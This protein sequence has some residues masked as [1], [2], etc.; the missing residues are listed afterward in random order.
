MRNDVRSHLD[1]RAALR[2]LSALSGLLAAST[3]ISGVALAETSPNA[4]GT[5]PFAVEIAPR[6]YAHK[7]HV[8]LYAPANE[9][10]I[11]NAGFVVGR[12]AVAVIDTGG[13]ARVGAHLHQAI[14][15]VTQLPI[16][17]VINTHMHPDHV[18][19]NS[20]FEADQPAFV[21]HHKLAR[22]LSARAERYLAI[23]GELLGA[24]VFAGTK[25]V[26]PTLAISDV[27]KLDLG[28]REIIIEPQK[29][30]HTDNDLIVRDSETGTVFLGD[31]L[32]S[33]HIPTLDGSILGWMSVLDT[34]AQAPAQRVV[35][36]HGPP[37]MP[38]P[39]AAKPIR[40]YLQVVTDEIRAM[41]KA[42]HTLSDATKTVGFSERDAWQ[43]FEDYHVRNVSAAFAE[44]E[45]E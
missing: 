16:R 5:S 39:D 9:G 29:T 4:S 34:L 40:H 17:Y 6:V 36:G 23:N 15:Q 10:D 33:E 7:G 44:L 1:R 37:S 2:L 8:A 11:S 18:F 31:L 28:G 13:S 21:G 45:W 22:G 12:D 27:T 30:A 14:R 35:P 20:A 3:K 19:G 43:L 26:L 32:F 42:D 38:W 25:I 41:I 24:D